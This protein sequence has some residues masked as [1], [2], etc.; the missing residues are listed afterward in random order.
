MSVYSSVRRVFFYIF[1]PFL[2]SS[3]VS[4]PHSFFLLTDLFLNTQI[5]DLTSMRLLH[6][7]SPPERLDGP[8]MF[9][10]TVSYDTALGIAKQLD[11]ALI[12]LLWDPV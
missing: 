11:V 1:G 3:F 7:T 10:S 9:R 12:D 6:C 5:M 4:I 8:P 2:Y